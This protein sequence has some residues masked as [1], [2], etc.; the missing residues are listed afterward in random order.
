MAV[1]MKWWDRENEDRSTPV[2][3]HMP[4]VISGVSELQS[5]HVGRAVLLA[6]ADVIMTSTTR[7]L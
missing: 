5:K 3:N 4:G 1:S 6:C 7:W 2:A